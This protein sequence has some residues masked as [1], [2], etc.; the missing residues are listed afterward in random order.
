[1]PCFWDFLH[2]PTISPSWQH[3]TRPLVIV[4]RGLTI[5]SR[6]EKKKK[7]S[8]CDW[9][10]TYRHAMS[11]R[12]SLC[13]FGTHFPWCAETVE[14]KGKQRCFFP[15]VA[16]IIVL[17]DRRNIG[18]CGDR[19]CGCDFTTIKW[20]FAAYTHVHYCK[21]CSSKVQPCPCWIDLYRNTWIW[22]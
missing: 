16:L 10:Q 1:M 3:P 13:D 6:R 15:P 9:T 22:L 18:I 21:N 8:F 5:H 19:G 17:E 2:V 14:G 4:Q 11:Y 7:L 20:Q 12:Q